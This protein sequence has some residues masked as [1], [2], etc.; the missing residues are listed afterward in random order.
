MKVLLVNPKCNFLIDP[1]V[2]SPL[3][4]W[5]V[6]AAVDAAGHE[7]S[8]IDLNEK[9]EVPFGYDAYLVTGTTP[10]FRSMAA[11][12]E[13]LGRGPIT[14]AGGPHA[15]IA[16]SDLQ[17]A[18]YRWV[19]RGEGEQ[20]AV[21]IL[22]GQ[23]PEGTVNARRLEMWEIPHPLR[24]WQHKYHYTL[25]GVKASHALLS[26]GC[27]YKCAFCCHALWD[28][29]ML[30]TTSWCRWEIERALS[31]TAKN[32]YGGVMFYDDTF[33]ISKGRVRDIGKILQKHKAKWRCFGRSSDI[34]AEMANIL[35]E[36]GCVEVGLGIESGS[37]DILHNVRKGTT[38]AQNTQAVVNLRQAGVRTKAFLVVGL[39]GEN[40]DTAHETR[41]WIRQ[42]RPD[43][44]DATIFVPYPGSPIYEHPEK[45][46]IQWDGMEASQ[47]WYKGI[48]GKYVSLVS[49]S[50]LSRQRIAELRDELDAMK[51]EKHGRSTTVARGAVP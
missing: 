43:E 8:F 39:P 1:M 49:T 23:H 38:V 44:W 31:L 2:F 20:V 35:G 50:A 45:Y 34:D 9:E 42:A 19:V 5:Y 33:T 24:R 11:I 46:D 14:I 17:R 13:R 40:E 10:Q 15:S 25:D 37:D 48:P 32:P 30:M 51:G 16:P 21:E 7:V 6:A 41:Q 28:K 3:G 26:R 22:A 47:M 27:P 36:Y 12:A 29:C 18:G 4:L